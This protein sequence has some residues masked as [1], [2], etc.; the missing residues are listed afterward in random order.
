VEALASLDGALTLWSR[1]NPEDCGPPGEL[2]AR[3]D[4]LVADVLAT[5]DAAPAAPAAPERAAKE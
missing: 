4:A 3:R 2:I 1:Q 5:L